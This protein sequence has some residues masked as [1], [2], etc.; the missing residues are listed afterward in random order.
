MKT[1][2]KLRFIAEKENGEIGEHYIFNSEYMYL[3]DLKKNKGSLMSLWIQ[4]RW[5]FNKKE[6]TI[7]IE[8]NTYMGIS[9]DERNKKI[10]LIFDILRSTMW[11]APSNAVIYNADGSIYRILTP[12]ELLGSIASKY[13]KQEILIGKCFG[14]LYPSWY[15]NSKGEKVVGISILFPAGYSNIYGDFFE[16]REIDLETGEFGE[17]LQDGAV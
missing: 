2:D 15:K 14:G 3:N 4:L 12:P 9:I 16:V 5:V 17:V 7:Q 13:K 11:K 8:K 10:L 1:F 6:I